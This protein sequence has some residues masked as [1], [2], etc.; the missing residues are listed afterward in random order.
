MAKDKKLKNM[1]NEQFWQIADKT[2]VN[3]F[4]K[5]LEFHTL[6]PKMLN[7]GK[8]A[9]MVKKSHFQPEHQPETDQPRINSQF[10]DLSW[11]FSGN[12]T[13]A[14]ILKVKKAVNKHLK[15]D[16]FQSALKDSFNC[17]SIELTYFVKPEF[18]KEYNM[19]IYRGDWYGT[20]KSDLLF[21][22]DNWF[23]SDFRAEWKRLTK[24]GEEMQK[25]SSFY[26]SVSFL[27]KHYINS[28]YQELTKHK[29]GNRPFLSQ[30]YRANFSAGTLKRCK[31]FTFKSTGRK[32]LYDPDAMYC[33]AYQEIDPFITKTT[34]LNQ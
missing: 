1:K 31:E 6:D 18:L 14:D 13:K 4:I 7:Y 25:I 30:A 28:E 32:I 12:P 10:I 9:S 17:V 22:L 16:K 23:N 8:Y 26:L 15:T 2:S 33:F 24:K 3:D 5:L 21:P 34:E 20:I 19:N 29:T 11:H 27:E